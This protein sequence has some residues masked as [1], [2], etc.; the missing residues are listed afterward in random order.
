MVIFEG[1]EYFY[2]WE[3]DLEILYVF[4]SNQCKI[5][6]TEITDFDKEPETI[7]KMIVLAFV[8]A[9][10]KKHKAKKLLEDLF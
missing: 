3:P 6:T 1:N 8:E 2:K 4:D 10:V 7:K 5:G 9:I